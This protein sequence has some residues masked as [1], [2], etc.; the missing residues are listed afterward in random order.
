MLTA[1]SDAFL[2]IYCTGMIISAVWMTELTYV[3]ILLAVIGIGVT[4]HLLAI[5]TAPK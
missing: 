5:K 3:R 2:C 4:W 1:G